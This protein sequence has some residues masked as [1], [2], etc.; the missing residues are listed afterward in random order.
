MNQEIIKYARENNLIITEKAL[1]LLNNYNY[2]KI[3]EKLKGKE[4]LFVK[5]NDI[6]KIQ[7]E[8]N[9]KEENFEENF[10]NNFIILDKYDITNK[11]YSQGS[12]EDFHKLFIDKYNTISQIL[13]N[14]LNCEYTTI[15]NAKNLIKNQKVD[16]IGMVYEK[17]MSK[18]ENLILDVDD[19]TGRIKL[20]IL[21]KDE[22]K[23]EKY[24][25]TLTDNVLGFKCNV[26]SKDMLIV[27]E[28][29]YPDIPLEKN[30]STTTI[31]KYIAIIGDTHVGSKLFLEK[32]FAKFIDWI[33]G[34]NGQKEIIE[35]IK[36]LIIAGDLVDGVGIYPDQYDE[37]AITDVFK[38]YELFEDYILKIRENIEIF[39]I[40]GNH[41]AVR[42]SDPQPA[43]D[44]KYLPRLYTKKNIHIMGSPSWVIFDGLKTLMYHGAS[45][46]GIYAEIKGMQMDKPDLAMKEVLIR[47]DLM[48]QYGH[49]QTFVPIEKNLMT[50]NEIPDIFITADVHHHA[51]SKYK[52]THLICSSCWQSTTKYQ[53]EKGHVPTIAKVLLF[54]LKDET[55]LIKDFE[56]DKNE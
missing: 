24:K 20:V 36:Y 39:I 42:L 19:P 13:K 17:R 4:I 31:D 30:K 53:I 35:K 47:R 2:K 12:V 14:R 11:N 55:L 48:P 32:E 16:I 41:D 8:K 1:R 43:I 46:H 25:Q 5:E 40:S 45:L 56:E 52:N 7:N 10:E 22:E 21:N 54:N 38:Q 29:I 9:Q 26:L 44:K 18:N 49:R 6:L 28:I 51:Y 33:N 34:E 27:N 3:I 50:I 23:F 15:E 37:L